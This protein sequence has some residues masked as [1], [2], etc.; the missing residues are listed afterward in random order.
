M[1][2]SLVSWKANNKVTH[3]WL[4]SQGKLFLVGKDWRVMLLGAT[5]KTLP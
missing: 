3:G 5:T 1:E 2:Q 4:S